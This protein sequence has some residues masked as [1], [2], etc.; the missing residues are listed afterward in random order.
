MICHK[1]GV[2]IKNIKDV[3]LYP[4]FKMG[5]NIFITH[6]TIQNI[7]ILLRIKHIKYKNFKNCVLNV[8]FLDKRL[9]TLYYNWFVYRY[10]N[11]LKIHISRC[12]KTLGDTLY[13][14]NID[15][16]NKPFGLIKP[17]W[18][19]Q[20]QVIIHLLGWMMCEWFLRILLTLLHNY[21]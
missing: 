11:S 12:S 19:N 13:S 3:P 2:P 8:F 16:L 10:L 20:W 6:K 14:V 9:A 7:I 21:V 17:L 18:T 4:F 5:R 15:Y 1:V